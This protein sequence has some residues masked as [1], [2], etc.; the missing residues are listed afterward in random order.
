MSPVRRSNLS[1]RSRNARRMATV[2]ANENPDERSDRNERSRANISQL[3]ERLSQEQRTVVQTGDR[4]RQ[5]RNRAQQSVQINQNLRRRRNAVNVELERVAFQYDCTI[6]YSELPCVSIGAMAVVCPHCGAL[7][8]PSETPGLCCMSGKVK[9]PPLPDPP[10]P[11]R[12][13]IYDDIPQSRQFFMRAQQYNGC[14]KK[15]TSFGAE[16]IQDNHSYNPIFKV[17]SFDQSPH[18]MNIVNRF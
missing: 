18:S 13:L 5:Q 15:M 4:D 1:R 14:F 7:K 12:S 16:V 17:N 6:E 8:L 2:R 10:E 3:R 9:L 11:L